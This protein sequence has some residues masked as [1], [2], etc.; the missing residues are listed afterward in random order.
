VGPFATHLHVGEFIDWMARAREL[1]LHEVMLPDH[2]WSRRLHDTN[3][4][5]RHRRE[6]AD[7]AHVLKASLDRRRAEATR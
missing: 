4:G 7:F 3:Q 5:V 2:L 6:M 1:G